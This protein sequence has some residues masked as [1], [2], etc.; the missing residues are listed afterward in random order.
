METHSTAGRRRFPGVLD[1]REQE[2]A[3]TWAGQNTEGQC[4]RDY[5]QASLNKALFEQRLAGGVGVGSLEHSR[6]G[7]S[8]RRLVRGV[9]WD[10]EGWSG[11]RC[12][13]AARWQERLWEPRALR[14]TPHA[15]APSE[16]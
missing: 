2:G 14:R 4:S 6:Q 16:P 8:L 11:G 3:G 12:G 7:Q 15:L 5:V 10:P 1:G 13:C 9:P